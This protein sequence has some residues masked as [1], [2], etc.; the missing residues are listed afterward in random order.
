MTE[1]TPQDG[2]VSAADA[3]TVDPVVEVTDTATEAATTVEDTAKTF[4]RAYVEKLRDEA[5]THRLKAKRVD[6]A[7]ARLLASLVTTDG[8]L[9]NPAELP[10]TD[11][12][13]D[14][15]GIVDPAKVSAAVDDLLM[16]KPYL[17]TP[18]APPPLP[19]GVRQD[20]PTAPSLLELARSML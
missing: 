16:V 1:E 7:N 19:Q 17:Q 2:P 6:T 9:V 3:T 12:L 20:A 4:D 15:D 14:D 5:A 10:L 8:R 18:A 13:L 11:A